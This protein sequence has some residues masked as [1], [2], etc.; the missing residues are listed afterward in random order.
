MRKTNFL[1]I[2][3]GLVICLCPAVLSAHSFWINCYESLAHAPGHVMLSLGYGHGIPMDDLLD[4]PGAKLRVDSYE[5]VAPDMRRTGLPLPAEGEETGIKTVS[6]II[7]RGGDLG[8]RKLSFTETTGDGVYQ[9]G[10]VSKPD[11]YT[12]YVNEKGRKKWVIE[13]M[14]Q[15]ENAREIIQ[16]SKYKAMAKAYF[17]KGRWHE[18]KPLGHDLEIIPLTDLTSVKAGDMVKF[19]VLFMGKKFSS[20]PS[21]KERITVVSNTFGGPDGFYLGDD[22]QRGEAAIRI[23][24]PGQWVATVYYVQDVEKDELLAPLADKCRQVHY[25][26]TIS[27]TVKP[28]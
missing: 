24:T 5:L 14:D 8:I 19:K 18:P 7:V 16:S 15:V 27:F 1:R 20:I 9:I 28:G 6:D 12:F 17:A 21:K 26:A 25:V 3:V 22:I 2:L 4:S 10:A 11:F 23:P 13:S